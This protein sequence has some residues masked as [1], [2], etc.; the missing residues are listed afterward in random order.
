MKYTVKK[1]WGNNSEDFNKK[2][3]VIKT[4]GNAGKPYKVAKVSVAEYG[5]QKVKVT[6]WDNQDVKVEDVLEGEI[7]EKEFNGVKYLELD[8]QKESP[9]MTKIAQIEFALAK[10]DK[11]IK[12]IVAEVKR[13]NP[14]SN[15]TS[16]GTKVPDFIPN[17]PEQAQDFGN[18]MEVY[19]N[20]MA[21]LD[22]MAEEAMARD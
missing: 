10:H 19:E 2:P 3:Y 22:A 12:E 8:T 18:K 21:S 15:L 13:L 11:Y 20:E 7:K 9:I 6:K 1:V 17:T 16:A 4:G 14:S 5:D